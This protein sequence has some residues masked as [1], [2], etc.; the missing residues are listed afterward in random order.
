MTGQGANRRKL[1]VVLKKVIFPVL[2][3]LSKEKGLLAINCLKPVLI[4]VSIVG[5]AKRAK[6]NNDSTVNKE[7]KT[8][9]Y[10]IRL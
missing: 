4:G 6:V 3:I 8:N 10:Y 7:I 2:Q 5:K 1:K 9:L